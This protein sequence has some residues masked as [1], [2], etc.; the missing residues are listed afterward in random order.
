MLG[1]KFYKYFSIE[2]FENRYCGVDFNERK[3]FKNTEDVIYLRL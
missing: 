2:P 1:R 3:L